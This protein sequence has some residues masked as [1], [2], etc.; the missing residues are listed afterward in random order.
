MKKI[1]INARF[2]LQPVTGVQRYA[3]ELIK[4]MIEH[5]K[6]IYDFVFILPEASDKNY[7]KGVKLVCDKTLIKS[8]A[9]WQQIKLPILAK[10]VKAD[11]LWSPCNVGPVFP[12]MPHV[13]NIFDGAV[14]KNE[15]WYEWKFKVYYRNI[16]KILGR[17]SLAVFTCSEFSKAELIKYG[18]A[19]SNK[20]HTV[21][22]AISSNFKSVKAKSPFNFKYVLSLGSRDPRKNI[23][24]L[25]KAWGLLPENIKAGR[26]LVLVGGESQAFLK[27]DFD[28]ISPDIHLAGYVKDEALPSLYSNAD[29]FVYPSFY[30]GFG[31]PPLEAMACGCPVIT[32]KVSSLPEACGD[33]AYY[34][35]PYSVNDIAK[36]ISEVLTNEKLRKK[37]IVDGFLNTHKFSWEKSAGKMLEI[38]ENLL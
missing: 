33:A 28:V 21:H 5:P 9:I 4:A 23:S 24:S 10:A 18:I 22:G 32:S 30:E 36:G 2:L 38:F 7:L 17:K 16:F 34:V 3:L 8:G 6:N 25:V 26:K 14:Y 15:S 29:C 11:F 19:D 35:N 31:F 20:I 13:I 12:G 27:E 37:M 1:A